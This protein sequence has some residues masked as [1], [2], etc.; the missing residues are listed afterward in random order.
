MWG[1]SDREVDQC[2]FHL[3]DGRVGLG[4]ESFD[5]FTCVVHTLGNDRQSGCGRGEAESGH[6]ERSLTHDGA[7]QFGVLV[8]RIWQHDQ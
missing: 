1:K 5:L 2:C 3:V 4:T 6:D 7:F 8:M